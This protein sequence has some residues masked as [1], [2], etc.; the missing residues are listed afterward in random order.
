M[1]V[2]NEIT[3]DEINMAIHDACEQYNIKNIAF[4]GGKPTIRKDIIDIVKEAAR[5]APNV[6]LT[7]NGYYF[8]TKENVKELLG[9]SLMGK[10]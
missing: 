1:K 3:L 7:T 5:Y 2:R 6:S 4:T 8:K 10:I 9:G